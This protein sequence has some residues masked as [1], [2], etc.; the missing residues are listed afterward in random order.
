MAEAMAEAEALYS[1]GKLDVLL[2][3]S[4]C[5]EVKP[6]MGQVRAESYLPKWGGKTSPPMSILSQSND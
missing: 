4:K 6:E 5:K 1:I 3:V 2:K